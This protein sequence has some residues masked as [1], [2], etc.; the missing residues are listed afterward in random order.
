LQAKQS[1]EIKEA[2]RSYFIFEDDYIDVDDSENAYVSEFIIHPDW[3]P[4]DTHYTADIAIAVLKKPMEIGDKVQ[5]IC[6]NTPSNPIQSFAGEKAMIFGWGYTE[7]FEIVTALRHVEIPLVDQASCY[8]KSNPILSR[9]MSDTSFCAGAKDGKTG[10]C[11][12]IVLL[13][14]IKFAIKM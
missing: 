14:F 5:H 12:G 4:K 13:I 10:A 7:D 2:S 1:K 3:D 9:I 6:L 11:S 8:N